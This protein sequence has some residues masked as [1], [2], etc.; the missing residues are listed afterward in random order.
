MRGF[1]RAQATLACEVEQNLPS[2]LRVGSGGKHLLLG[3][4]H[5]SSRDHLH[6]TRDL[7]N[8]LDAPDSPPDLSCARQSKLLR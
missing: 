8:V 5:P 3:A 2:L 4:A 1:V 6:G 7:R